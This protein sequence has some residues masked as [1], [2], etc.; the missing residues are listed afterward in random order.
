MFN[1]W[2]FLANREILNSFRH[3]K[4]LTQSSWCQEV[5]ICTFLL[6]WWLDY[7]KAPALSLLSHVWAPLCTIL[8]EQFFFLL[9]HMSFIKWS[10][11][12]FQFCALKNQRTGHFPLRC[13]IISEQPSCR[14]KMLQTE[15]SC[16]SWIE[17]NSNRRIQLCTFCLNI[18]S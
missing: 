8:P 2:I 15:R 7:A 6:D 1:L 12:Y 14:N 11:S 16:K 10:F 5:Y 18:I 13:L 3:T 4:P 9:W 17:E